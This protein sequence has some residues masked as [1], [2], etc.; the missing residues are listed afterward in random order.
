MHDVVE[1]DLEHQL[2][3]EST[4]VQQVNHL[5]ERLQ[6]YFLLDEHNLEDLYHGHIYPMLLYIV[7]HL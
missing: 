5:L 3:I 2:D 4:F 6:H 1:L 7:E